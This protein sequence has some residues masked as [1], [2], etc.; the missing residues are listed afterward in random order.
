MKKQ[1]FIGTVVLLFAVTA[2]V[3]ADQGNMNDPLGHLR[4]ARASLE[5]AERNKGGHRER[6]IEHVNA[7]IHE[8]EAGVA[9]ARRHH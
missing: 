2:P 1:T 9:F 4:A 6:A 5:R 8:V 7:V 3:I